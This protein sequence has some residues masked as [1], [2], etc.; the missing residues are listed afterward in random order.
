MDNADTPDQLW[1]FVLGSGGKYRLLN[2]GEGRA[3]SLDTLKSGPQF[4]VVMS[5]TG[6]SGQTWTVTPLGGGKFRLTNEYAGAEKSLDTSKS[7]NRFVVVMG[8]TGDFSGQ[9]WTL[10]NETD[11]LLTDPAR[12]QRLHKSG[13]VI[14]GTG[15][16]VFGGNLT[17]CLRGDRTISK[18]PSQRRII[19]AL[20]SVVFLI[21]SASVASQVIGANRRPADRRQWGLPPLQR[22]CRSRQ[23]VKRAHGSVT[24]A[25]TADATDQLWKLV[26]VGG[27]K[28]RLV[29]SAAGS[30]KSLDNTKSGDQFSV[31]IGGTGNYTGQ[32]WTLT[33]LAGGKYRL[34]NDYASGTKSLD[35]RKSGDQ[36]SV[37]MGDTGN[38]SGQ[39]WSLKS[40][41]QS[42]VINNPISVIQ[43]PNNTVVINQVPVIRNPNNG[44][45]VVPMTSGPAIPITPPSGTA[46][47]PPAGAPP[48]AYNNVIIPWDPNKYPQKGGTLICS[49]D[50]RASGN[51]G[52]AKANWVGK[53][54]INLKC[55]KGFYDPIW[56]GT[57]WDF[58]KDDQKGTWVRGTTA[59][60]AD[61]AVWRAP[62]EPLWPQQ[63]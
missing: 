43:N 21:I 25:D 57:C 28:Y 13:R 55:E 26:S 20:P 11:S 31:A 60:T 34:T 29:N 16:K 2:V 23:I 51:C 8:D 59:V 27:G 22:L 42:V 41:A 46:S 1:K 63:G 9:T 19:Y 10:I 14:G 36:F 48:L 52:L 12:E 32:F 49:A 58:P 61:D 62:K 38:F 15:Q 54:E 39:F 53:H 45:V 5:K 3:K 33:P 30:G 44:V 7:G 17:G 50:L 18:S 37:V 6:I 56:G 35:A 4:S 40:T 47:Q 24:M